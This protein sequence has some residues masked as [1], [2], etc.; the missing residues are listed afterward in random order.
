MEAIKELVKIG[1]G[2]SVLAEWVAR[3]E[4]AEGSLVWL[5]LP[6]PR[7]RRTWSVATTD[8][9]LTLAEQTFVGL[10]AAV[11]GQVAPSDAPGAVERLGRA[12][13][14]GM[15]GRVTG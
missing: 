15:R 13:A 1:L 7:L 14:S 4:L 9:P 3:A 2:V 11:A 10:C 12:P 5:G 6:G 8:R